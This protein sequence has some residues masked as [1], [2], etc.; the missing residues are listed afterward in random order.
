MAPDARKQAVPLRGAPKRLLWSF[1]RGQTPLISLE[2]QCQADT[3]QRER[4]RREEDERVRPKATAEFIL[5]AKLFPQLILCRGVVVDSCATLYIGK[6]FDLFTRVVL[7]V[8]FGKT[9]VSG[10]LST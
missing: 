6:H 8:L 5:V 10:C 9:L 4:K 2:A 1:Q 7:A 3:L